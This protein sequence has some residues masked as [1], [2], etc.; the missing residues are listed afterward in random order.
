MDYGPFHDSVHTRSGGGSRPLTGV[1]GVRSNSTS[2]FVSAASRIFRETL[3]GNLKYRFLILRK[4]SKQ[5][6]IL[7]YFLCF[8]K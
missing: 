6:I 5:A 1:L 4:N 2:F 7:F 3:V 8:R